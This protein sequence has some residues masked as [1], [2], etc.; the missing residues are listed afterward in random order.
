MGGWWVVGGMQSHFRVQ[1]IHC[2]EVVL[3][4]VVVVVVTILIEVALVYGQFNPL[5]PLHWEKHS[6]NMF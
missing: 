1:P 5:L 4:C 6:P 2:V 3:R